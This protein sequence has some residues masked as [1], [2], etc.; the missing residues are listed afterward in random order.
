MRQSLDYQVEVVQVFF[1][2]VGSCLTWWANSRFPSL[3]E[4]TILDR[5]LSNFCVRGTNRTWHNKYTVNFMK[6][7]FLLE[8]L[9]ESELL[10]LTDQIPTRLFFGKTG[11]KELPLNLRN[12]GMR[13]R[14]L[15]PL[16]DS[17]IL[18][19]YLLSLENCV[20][21]SS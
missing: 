13:L 5:R 2:R 15:N 14:L 12:V 9:V 11:Q 21:L 4:N 20:I 16:L 3:P 6:Y 8:I 10:V 19:H 17:T 7:I 18:C 1:D